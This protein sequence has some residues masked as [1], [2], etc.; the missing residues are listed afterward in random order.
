MMHFE[1]LFF[2]WVFKLILFIKEYFKDNL[3]YNDQF[4]I[5]LNTGFQQMFLEC[6]YLNCVS[7]RNCCFYFVDLK[8]DIDL[9]CLR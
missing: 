3:I 8:Q 1:G 9:H 5:W 6:N 2:R 7:N 4:V